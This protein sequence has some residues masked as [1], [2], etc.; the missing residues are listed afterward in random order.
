MFLAELHS[1]RLSG[2]LD[3]LDIELLHHLQYLIKT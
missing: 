1:A 2:F 3:V